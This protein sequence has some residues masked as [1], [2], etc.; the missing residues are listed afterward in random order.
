MLL[1]FSSA[2]IHHEHLVKIIIGKF[3]LNEFDN[4]E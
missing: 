4:I 1:H 3:K 2:K